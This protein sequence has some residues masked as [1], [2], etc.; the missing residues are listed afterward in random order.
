[1]RTNATQFPGGVAVIV[2]FD[3]DKET[4]LAT[5]P[6]IPVPVPV[7]QD[8]NTRAADLTVRYEMPAPP[9]CE[10]HVRD[11]YGSTWYRRTDGSFLLA[12]KDDADPAF[13]GVGYADQWP[14]LLDRRGPLELVP[15]TLDE[16]AMAELY[17]PPGAR[18]GDPSTPCGY[19]ECS[20]GI[21][22]AGGHFDEH[23]N[24]LGQTVADGSTTNAN[25][26]RED[27]ERICTC[28]TPSAHTADCPRYPY[29]RTVIDGRDDEST[30]LHDER[31][32]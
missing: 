28:L 4:E 31:P 21:H 25:V 15:L 19:P 17:G 13:F 24:P 16:L 2:L 23:G 26:T 12:D 9:V 6:I 20:G 11:R 22:H 3:D 5:A 10:R 8:P 7:P 18:W 27:M 14:W 30:P 1:M 29:P 32:F